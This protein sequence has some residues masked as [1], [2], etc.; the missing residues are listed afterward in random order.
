MR[1]SACEACRC[2]MR[3]YA[4]CAGLEIELLLFWFCL[5]GETLEQQHS[6]HSVNGATTQT[7]LTAAACDGRPVALGGS[8]GVKS[9]LVRCMVETKWRSAPTKTPT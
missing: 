4:A 2:T 5:H 9:G 3:L 8:Q 7:Q 6:D 1:V